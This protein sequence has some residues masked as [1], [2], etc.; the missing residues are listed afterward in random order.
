MGKK[1]VDIFIDNDLEVFSSF[2]WWCLGD[3]WEY[4]YFSFLVLIKV[5]LLGGVKSRIYKKEWVFVIG[6]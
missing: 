4:F 2:Y 5:K 6:F 3:S 1:I